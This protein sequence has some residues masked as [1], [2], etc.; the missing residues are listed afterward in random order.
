VDGI[1]ALGVTHTVMLTGDRTRVARAVADRLGIETVKAELMPADKKH[2]VSLARAEFGAVAMV[3]DGTND[4]PA[5]ATAD[6]AV[7]MGAAGTDVALETADVALMADDLTKL[8]YTI[9]L[10][11][12]ARRVIAQNVTLSI[13]AIAVLA[14][15]AMTG[16]FTLTEGVLL[17][18][19]YALLIIGNGLRLLGGRRL[20]RF[21]ATAATPET[22]PE[23][24]CECR[25][26]DDV[27]R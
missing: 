8:P 23:P 4:A 13:A 19:A 5:L 20:P 11:Q 2:A 22:G 16:V 9:A 10:A 21:A 15:A 12:R 18:E 24:A 1:R 7:V 26:A 25:A 14:V 27:N 6:V 3:G 17:N